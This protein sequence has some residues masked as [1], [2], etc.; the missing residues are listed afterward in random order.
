MSPRSV[1]TLKLAPS[2]FL[3]P[4]V[5]IKEK[6]NASAAIAVLRTLSRKK[7]STKTASSPPQMPGSRRPERV[8]YTL[9]KAPQSQ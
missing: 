4:Q 9:A 5:T 1:R 6:G 3:P 7:Y 8:I 2:T